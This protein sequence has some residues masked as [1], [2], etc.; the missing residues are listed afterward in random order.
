MFFPRALKALALALQLR[1]T[2]A[3]DT[4]PTAVTTYTDGTGAQYAICADTDLQGT[5]AVATQNVA[6][7]AACAQLCSANST[8][9][10]A[11]YDTSRKVCHIKDTAATL[12]W[13]SNTRYD[14]IS[15]NNQF[16]E[17]TVIARCVFSETSYTGAR[18]TFQTCPGTDL[19]GASARIVTGVASSAACAKLCDATSGCDKAVFDKSVSVC[20]I[21]DTTAMLIWAMNKRYDVIQRKVAATPAATGQWS[22]IIR[23]PIIPVAAYVVPESPDTSRMLIFAAWGGTTFGGAGGETQFAD[24]NW[25]TGTVSQKTISNTNHDMFCPGISQ[26]EDGRIIITGGSDAE[27]TSIYNPK[28]NTFA[29]GP[30]MKVA[31]GYQSST[32]LSDGRVFTIGGSYSGGYGGKDG[33]IYDPATNTW[34]FLAGAEVD[35]MLTDDHEGIWREDNHG[36]LYGWKNGSV[37]QAGPSRTQHWY[38]TAGTGSVVQAATRDTD[39]AM[40]GIN[41]MYDVGK[42]LSAGGASDYD[43][44]TA[45]K[46]AHI[47]TIGEPNQGSTVEKV[48]D[49]AYARA[50]GN[51]VVL[52]DGT[53]LVT[54]GQKV[55]HVFTDTDGALAA[56]LFNP[57]TKTWKTLASAAVARNYH[58]VS[59]LLPDG[60]VFS[61]GGGLCYVGS[62]GASD[63]AC[64]LAVNHA[65]GQIFTPPYLFNSD[66]T[67][68]T[69]PVIS[70]VSSYSMRVGSNLSV[71]MGSAA[72]GVKF[73]LVR[74]GSATHSINTDQRR[75]PIGTT[76]QSGTQYSFTLEKDSGILLPGYYY[77]FALS[78]TGVPSVAKTI[79]ITL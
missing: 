44:S 19:Q 27:K 63:A 28:T 23:L 14:V 79:Q 77:L 12:T 70:S 57:T 1:V 51:G 34:T 21:K 55:A 74:I 40:C 50:F 46:T 9:I 60:T 54:G 65:D 68:A 53:V 32:T 11:V 58:S 45:W 59:L 33:E 13:V 64:N 52:P 37:F 78:S 73:S 49:M 2:I 62:K 22:D 42:I 16:S 41:V 67:A 30:D 47:T 31:R 76:T 15:L 29:R 20:H 26:L 69:R 39:D 8:C 48:S 71:T 3:L 72:G 7:T 5:T 10:R 56:E 25:K 66:N 18:G 4:C 38:G 61:G 75:I 35:V 24:Y 17:G 36:W 6:S 43:A